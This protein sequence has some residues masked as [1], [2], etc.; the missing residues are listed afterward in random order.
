MIGSITGRAE[1]QVIRIALIY[2]LLDG[3]PEIELV[4]LKAA[5]AVWDFC[6]ESARQTFGDSL[7]DPIADTILVALR[8]A[9]TAGRSR[10]EDQQPIRPPPSLDTASGGPD[11]AGAT[12]PS[13]VGDAK[14]RGGRAA[15]R[16]VVRCR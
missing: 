11:P 12:R 15:A 5:I 1:A 14:N 6:D 10:V 2:A 13:V 4:H 8:K 16:D 3:K 9:G 7:G